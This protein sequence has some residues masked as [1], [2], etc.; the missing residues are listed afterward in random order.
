MSDEEIEQVLEE[1][2][3][4]RTREMERMARERKVDRL[5]DL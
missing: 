4:R 5:G 1:R 3:I 2:A